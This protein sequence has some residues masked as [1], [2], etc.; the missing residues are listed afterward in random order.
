MT[1]TSEGRPGPSGAGQGGAG[2]GRQVRV[3]K[4]GELVASQ[5]RGRIV[6]GE[7]AEGT[8]LPSESVLMT[9]FGVS[10]PTLRE[11]FRMLE[12]EGLITVLRGSRGGARV[13][14]PSPAALARQAGAVLQHRRARLKDVFEIR[15]LLEGQAA[16]RLAAARTAA[17]VA[18]IEELLA[19]EAHAHDAGRHNDFLTA[20]QDLH[21]GLV[22]LADSPTLSLLVRMLYAVV[23][24][25]NVSSTSVAPPDTHAALRE[26]THRSHRRL[27]TLLRDGTAGEVEAYWT[28]HLE[29]V[30][31]FLLTGIPAETAVDLMS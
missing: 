8:M 11:G 4:A 10:R 25:A 28:R 6:R 18:R 3:P 15:T 17:K 21:L 1:T 24:T 30:S 20:D 12:A 23:E 31:T 19:A 13:Q 7:L 14:V 9:Q 22:E 5:V 29:S 16:A 26:R 2:P 27:V